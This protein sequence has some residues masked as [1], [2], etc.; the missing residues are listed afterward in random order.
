MKKSFLKF[1]GIAIL[2]FQGEVSASEI[3]EYILK[4][5]GSCYEC[6]LEGANLYRQNLYKANLAYSN[7]E[8]ANLS[9][10]NLSKADLFESKLR[11]TNLSSADLF[12]I[13]RAHV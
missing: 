6:N 4:T 9:K 11:A 8:E 10:S 12:K 1:I 13:G 5:S 7:L 3:E 2:L